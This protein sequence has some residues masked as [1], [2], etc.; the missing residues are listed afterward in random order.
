MVT[1][2]AADLGPQWADTVQ[3]W[4][5]LG[6][7]GGLGGLLTGLAALFTGRRARSSSEA[8]KAEL[9][10]NH[11]SSLRDKVDILADEV[12]LIAGALSDYHKAMRDRVLEQERNLRDLRDEVRDLRAKCAERGE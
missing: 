10:P 3:S 9:R 5:T 6:G 4:A 1:A 11:G 2:L 12:T 7:L 8:V